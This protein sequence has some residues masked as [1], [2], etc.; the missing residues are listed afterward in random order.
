MES[1]LI[2]QVKAGPEN[3]A[4]FAL[5]VFDWPSRWFGMNVHSGNPD[6]H[7]AF[8]RASLFTQGSPLL[9]PISTPPSTY[10]GPNRKIFPKPPAKINRTAPREGDGPLAS[11]RDAASAR[12]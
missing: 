6:H 4:A 11:T 5:C 7:W 8:R 2:E 1:L 3:V 10:R 12:D 9:Y